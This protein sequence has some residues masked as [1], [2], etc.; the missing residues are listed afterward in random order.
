M[1]LNFLKSCVIAIV[2]IVHLC[3]LPILLIGKVWMGVGNFILYI[4]D[5]DWMIM[6]NWPW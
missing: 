4:C 5:T 1:A 3:M 2:V 6:E